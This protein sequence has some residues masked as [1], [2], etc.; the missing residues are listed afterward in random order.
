M[1]SPGE[2]SAAYSVNVVGIFHFT[3]EYSAGLVT[4]SAY[5]QNIA[6]SFNVVQITVTPLVSS[7]NE[8]FI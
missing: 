1:T 5:S 2:T 3:E 8:S 4:P 6:S 7:E